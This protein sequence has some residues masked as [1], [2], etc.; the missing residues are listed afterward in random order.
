MLPVA[1][2]SIVVTELPDGTLLRQRI[3]WIDNEGYDCFIIDIDD[4]KALPV[5]RRFSSV[6]QGLEDKELFIELVDPYLK[7]FHEE[8]IPDKH[9]NRRDKNWQYIK[10]A[11][12]LEN[13][14]DIFNEKIRWKMIQEIVEQHEKLHAMTVYKYLRRYWQRGKNINALLPN[15]EATGVKERNFVKSKPGPSHENVKYEGIPL[16]KEVKNQFDKILKKYYHVEGNST[17]EYAYNQLIKEYYSD[18]VYVDG[19]RAFITRPKRP[20]RRQLIYY[21]AKHY[22]TSE[23]RKKRIG[24]R[25]YN[26]TERP[27]LGASIVEGPGSEYQIDSTK[28]NVYLVSRFN[29]GEIIG[30]ATVYY[31]IDVFSREVAGF[32]I[33]VEEASWVGAMM[34]LANANMDKV[35]FCKEYGYEI[36]PDMWRAKHLPLSIRSDKGPEFTSDNIEPYLQV[37][38]I[39]FN[40]TPTGRADLKGIVEQ[41]IFRAEEKIKSLLPGY[42]HKD[43]G[44]RGAPDYRKDAVLTIEDYTKII[45][46]G[47]L[48]YNQNHWIDNYPVTKD[49]LRDNVKPIPNELWSWGIGKNTGILRY[50]DPKIV[51]LNL[52]PVEKASVTPRGIKFENMFYSCKYVEDEDWYYR[53][54]QET[55][56]IKV[57]YDP[58][59]VD[60][61]YIHLGNTDYKAC[62]LLSRN[63][64]Y[65]GMTFA[66]AKLKMKL[67]DHAKADHD[68]VVLTGNTNQIANIEKIVHEAVKRK[69]DR[70]IKEVKTTDIIPNRAVEKEAERKQSAFILTENNPYQ[71]HSHVQEKI[72]V[73]EIYEEDDDE[74]DLAFLKKLQEEKMR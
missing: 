51:K 59:L 61:I 19:K 2:N 70:Q 11:V 44:E 57:S 32:Y 27:V 49:M 9:K 66:E 29:P 53:A 55:W 74:I 21:N 20:S 46:E 40:N 48:N 62:E 10:E 8:N 31:V 38:L 58:R 30:R 42:V 64:V 1:V 33:G 23:H 45:I 7:V 52:L 39:K 12:S 47:I 5:Y 63:K 56:M 68:S 69:G 14:P 60:Y 13:E 15:Y 6:L 4:K 35:E 28:S 18:E 36:T 37:F 16:T 67:E 71:Q 41:Y 65:C 34:A 50:A 22:K 43:A 24:T 25:K 72:E 54:E 73:E 26:L 3:L 17:L